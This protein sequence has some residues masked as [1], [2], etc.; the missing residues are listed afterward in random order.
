MTRV[1]TALA[2]GSHDPRLCPPG[3]MS[4]VCPPDTAWQHYDCAFS[5]GII[6]VQPG[7]GPV[8]ACSG[9]ASLCQ[10]HMLLHVFFFLFIVNVPV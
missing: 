10:G 5:E 4:A 9:S 7:R 2:K 8:P 6:P 1:G 3:P